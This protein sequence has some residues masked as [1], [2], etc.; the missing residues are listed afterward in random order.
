[1]DYKTFGEQAEIE[2]ITQVIVNGEH[3]GEV[4]SYSEEG[5]IEQYRKLDSAIAGELRR[6][7]EEQD[8]SEINNED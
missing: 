7:F 6:Q 4:F 2:Y 8:E 3:A 1:M 5:L